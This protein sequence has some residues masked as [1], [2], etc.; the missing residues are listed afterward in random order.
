MTGKT[1]PYLPFLLMA[2]CMCVYACLYLCVCV[3][4]CLYMCICVYV[5]LYV[6][7]CVCM[8]VYMCALPSLWLKPNIEFLVIPVQSLM[9]TPMLNHRYFVLLN[10]NCI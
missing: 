1:C 8:A 3:Y 4:V 7:V 2:A 5:C 9:T 6:C 10:I